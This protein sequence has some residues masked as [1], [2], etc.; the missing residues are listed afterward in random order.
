MLLPLVTAMIGTASI[1]RVT[2]QYNPTYQHHPHNP[3]PRTFGFLLVNSTILP[4]GSLCEKM[5]EKWSLLEGGPG[6]HI[7]PAGFS[8]RERRCLL[9]ALLFASTCLFLVRTG[10]R[11]LS[12]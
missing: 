11:W 8:S 9:A 2:L 12:I 6:I 10:W 5:S 7:S 4:Y 1:A 3:D